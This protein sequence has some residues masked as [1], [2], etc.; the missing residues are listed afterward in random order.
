[1][2]YKN[3]SLGGLFLFIVKDINNPPVIDAG[4]GKLV[5]PKQIIKFSDATASD[6]EGS[7]LTYLWEAI[8]PD[9]NLVRLN[10]NQLNNGGFYVFGLDTGNVD[11]TFKLTVFDGISTSSDIVIYTVTNNPPNAD[12]GSDRTAS[13]GSFIGLG[14]TNNFDPDGDNLL[15]SWSQVSG[16]SIPILRSNH[17][18]PIIKIPDDYSA[19][20]VIFRLTVSDDL[21]GVATDDISIVIAEKTL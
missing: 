16:P 1:M 10:I 15:F 9:I 20:D 14:G 5:R 12:A 3:Y 17:P 21:G 4:T 19:S 6:P 8:N 7:M 18:Y 11:V 2:A 13:K